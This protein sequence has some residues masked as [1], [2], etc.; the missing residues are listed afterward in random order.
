V[1]EIYTIQPLPLS[2]RENAIDEIAK[3]VKKDGK[4]LVIARAREDDEPVN[5]PPWP[6]SKK[7]LS[8]FEKSGLTQIHFEDFLDDADP[9]TRRF[10]VEYR[11]ER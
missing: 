2:L 10:I 6:L 3:F 9:P 4:L 11:S 1:L 5:D 7:D 8:R